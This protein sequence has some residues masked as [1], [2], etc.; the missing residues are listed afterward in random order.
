MKGKHK[1]R[2]MW[3]KRYEGANLDDEDGIFYFKGGFEV[4]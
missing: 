2:W 4:A 1:G 3:K